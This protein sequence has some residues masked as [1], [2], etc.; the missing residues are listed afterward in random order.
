MFTSGQCLR[1][2][3][4][5]VEPADWHCGKTG[6]PLLQTACPPPPLIHILFSNL[7]IPAPRCPPDFLL[8]SLP[9]VPFSPSPFTPPS[10]LSLPPSTNLLIQT[11]LA[12]CFPHHKGPTKAALP[13]PPFPS[14]L[15]ILRGATEPCPAITLGARG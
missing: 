3:P 15:T 2:L 4:D 10:R 13:H 8:L 9:I 6:D 1:I 14:L 12:V 5:G 11:G 7:T